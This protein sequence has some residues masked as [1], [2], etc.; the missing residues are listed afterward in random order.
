M[1][2]SVL[3]NRLMAALLIHACVHTES[4]CSTLPTVFLHR[5]C[6][7]IM[8]SHGDEARQR[9]RE[10][11]RNT[12]PDDFFMSLTATETAV[13]SCHDAETTDPDLKVWPL[14]C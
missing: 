2:I 7:L 8:V 14:M 6:L 3:S 1:D 11:E 4:L 10:N 5:V 12:A 13:N 9:Q